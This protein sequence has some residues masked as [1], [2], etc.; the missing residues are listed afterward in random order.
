MTFT[1]NPEAFWALGKRQPNGCVYWR[2]RIDKA[3]YGRHGPTL[4]GTVYA[5]RSAWILTHGPI[6]SDLTVDH[7]C[8]SDSDCA[9][10]NNC[11]HRRCIN[12]AHL[13]LVTKAENVRA[14][15]HRPP[16]ALCP[17]GHDTTVVGRTKVGLCKECQ[18]LANQAWLARNPGYEA[19]RGKLRIRPAKP[20]TWRTPRRRS[21]EAI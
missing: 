1:N 4:T 15:H 9:E 8:H 5:H 17:K 11:K 18:R 13:R 19:Q 12:P 20:V 3:G 2:G 14:Q 21:E 10:G 16:P 6:E 7:L